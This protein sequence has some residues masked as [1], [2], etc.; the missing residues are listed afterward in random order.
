MAEIQEHYRNLFNTRNQI[1]GS[2]NDDELQSK[3][4]KRFQ[5]IKHR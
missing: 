3:F 5:E 4:N 1:E 2:T